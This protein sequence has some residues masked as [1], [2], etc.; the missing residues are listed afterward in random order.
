MRVES[1]SLLPLRH[2]S[3]SEGW[4]AYRFT[5]KFPLKDLGITEFRNLKYETVDNGF[6]LITVPYHAIMKVSI[7]FVLNNGGW[8]AA[9]NLETSGAWSIKANDD[10]GLCLQSYRFPQSTGTNSAYLSKHRAYYILSLYIIQAYSLFFKSF[11]ITQRCF[12]NWKNK[13][14]I[15]RKYILMTK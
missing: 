10:P 8:R 3:S 12:V 13:F 5:A 14:V 7:I 1:A 2:G 9:S 6:D 15:Y 4:I 11:L